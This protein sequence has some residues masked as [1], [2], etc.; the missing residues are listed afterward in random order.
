MKQEEAFEILK[1]GNNVF[2]TGPPGSGKTF[3]LNRY[4][5]YLKNEKRGVA[6]T[7]STGVAA[8]NMGGITLHSWSGMGIKEK[9]TSADIRKLLKKP[10]LKKRFKRIGVLIIDEVS[11]LHSFQFDLIDQICKAFKNN[12]KS[13]GGIQVVCSGDFFQLPP[14]NKKGEA[15]FIT[16]SKIW[17]NMD[18]KICYLEEQYRQEGGKLLDLLNCIRGNNIKKAK[19]LLLEN[20]FNKE[21]PSFNLTKLYT[22]NIDVDAINYI[23]LNKIIGKSFVYSMRS[24]GNK[25]IVFAFKKG[26]LAPERLILKEGA[27]VMFVKNNFEK[28]YVNGTLGKIVGFD[29]NKFPIVKTLIGRRIIATP[30]SWSIEEEGVKKAEITQIPLRLAWAITVHKSQGMNLDSAE[31]D[32]SKCFLE[33]MGYVALS[34]LRSFE[35]L[36][37]TGINETAF[38]VNKEALT[39]DK[40]FREMSEM[41]I[42]DFKEIFDKDKKNKEKEF[43]YSLPRVSLNEEK[44]EINGRKISTYEET[45]ILVKEKYSIKEI[46]EIRGLVKDTVLNHLEKI[47]LYEKD[48]N[49]DYL[50]PKK[51]F[52]RIKEAFLKTNTYRL[53]PVFDILD[54][55][56]S[57]E[58]IRTVR[59]F[60]EDKFMEMTKDNKPR[61][62]DTKKREKKNYNCRNCGRVIRHKG[63]CLPCNIKAKNESLDAS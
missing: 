63:N 22:H 59:L 57:Y 20:E 34:R 44:K 47:V 6:I 62:I 54:G 32:L 19:E 58:E 24:S 42:K 26:C 12:D 35:G 28:G 18:I 40:I 10:Y 4:I 1:S 48:I 29:E 55:K 2:L 52:K 15:K 61:T 17:N 9:L 21:V 25:D 14:I 27:K 37:I 30:L 11:M 33:G 53:K 7:A 51:D 8:T 13:F 46:V 49:L 45:K 36:R 43:V 41:V 3:L 60:I 50:K 16:R 39:L 56:F 31:I 38:L 5:D 23:E